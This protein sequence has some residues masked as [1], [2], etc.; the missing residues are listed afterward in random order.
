M[1][2]NI[3]TILLMLSGVLL[4]VVGAAVP[5]QG[6]VMRV[7]NIVVGVLFFGY[8]FYLQFLFQGGTYHI[9]LYA[10]IGPALLI[11]RTIQARGANSRATATAAA[12]RSR[13]DQE[14]AARQ[15][16]Q[17]YPGYQGVQDAQGSV[18]APQQGQFG[19]PRQGQF[20]AGPARHG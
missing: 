15:G 6:A 3:Y 16:Y 17:A 2:F 9:F 8:G 20:G 14:I 18:G 12:E 13:A 4:I 5:H 19:A 7:F 1:F 10:F 11:A